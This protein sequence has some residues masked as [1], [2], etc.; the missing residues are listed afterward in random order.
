[1]NG[2][3]SAGKG[4]LGLVVPVVLVIAVV[5]GIAF[6]QTR[7]K[8][9]KAAADR[10]AYLRTPE[11]YK[12]NVKEQ[13]KLELREENKVYLFGEVVNQGDRDLKNVRFRITYMSQARPGERRPESFSTGAIKAGATREFD[14]YFYQIP[15]KKMLGFGGHYK[16]SM[17]D[18]VFA[19]EGN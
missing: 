14:K 7:K 10:E 17:D 16:F 1:M 6:H 12:A 11:A 9:A 3:T 5:G 8:E 2:G 18:L 4:C 15:V 13:L 19:P